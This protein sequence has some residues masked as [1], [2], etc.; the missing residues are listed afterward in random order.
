[1]KK[2]F[3]VAATFAASLLL[4]FCVQAADRKEV[5]KVYNWSS[6]IAEGVI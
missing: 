2:F 4:A 1:M 6:Y 3:A 5:L